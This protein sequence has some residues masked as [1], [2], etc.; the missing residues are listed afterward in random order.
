[1]PRFF[2]GADV[3]HLNARSAK[4]V[5]DRLHDFPIRASQDLPE[6]RAGNLDE[7]GFALRP[8]QPRGL[9]PGCIGVRADPGLYPLKEF[10]P[11]IRCFALP[12]N[13]SSSCHR[14]EK[15]TLCYFHRCEKAVESISCLRLSSGFGICPHRN[16]EL[17]PCRS[18]RGPSGIAGPCTA[19]MRQRGIVSD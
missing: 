1:M 10:F 5:K 17:C 13:L 6:D 19:A 16:A 3:L 15:K 18:A 8:V 14:R 4:L 2:F 12:A 9:K 11:G 7:E